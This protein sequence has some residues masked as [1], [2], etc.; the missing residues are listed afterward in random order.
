[1][2]IRAGFIGL[3]NQGR[4]IAAHLAPA[5]FETTVYDIAEAPVKELVATG[6]RAAAIRW[7]GC[8][9][10]LDNYLPMQK[11]AKM[12]PSNSSAL[13]SPVISPPVKR[14]VFLNSFTQPALSCG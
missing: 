13:N 6:A 5:G 2:A 11:L 1:M 14:K 12:R 3:G 7:T 4:P 10:W 8:G 9:W